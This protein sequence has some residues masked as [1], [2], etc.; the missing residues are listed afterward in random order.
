[1]K[2]LLWHEGALGDLLLSRLAIAA[3]S[4]ETPVLLARS[5]VRGLF[6]TAGLVYRTFSTEWGLPRDFEPPETV[7]LFGQSLA[8]R[9][10]L[11]AKFPGS[12]IL[13][14]RT[15][16]PERIHVALFQWQEA[17]GPP[18]AIT[19]ARVLQIPHFKR[20]P[21][22]VLFHPG[23]GGRAK[24]Y[25]PEKL[26]RTLGLLKGLPLRVILGP[27]EGDLAEPFKAFPLIRSPEIETA[28]E[29]LSETALFVGNDSGLTHLAAALGVPVLALFGPTDPVL[30]APFGGP[31]RILYPFEKLT[32]ERLAYEIRRGLNTTARSPHRKEPRLPEGERWA[33]EERKPQGT[34]EAGPWEAEA[35]RTRDKHIP[36]EELES[37]LAG[38][39]GLKF[40]GVEVVV[41]G[42]EV[43]R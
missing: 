2:I 17:G 40:L 33:V 16:P 28:L 42:E 30:W 34:E 14:L 24:C 19:R 7:Y 1:M 20:K 43:L 26:K 32:P 39:A 3:F 9:E 15:R 38:F 23:S 8:L 29:A 31:V 35:L 18:P 27:A 11:S 37:N 4:D 6:E 13:I 10:T 5:E 41:V 21:E 12:K 25:P 36:T 22:Y